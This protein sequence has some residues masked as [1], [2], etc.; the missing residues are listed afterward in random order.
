MRKLAVF[1]SGWLLLQ[2]FGCAGVKESMNHK[3][4]EVHSDKVIK[5]Y[6]F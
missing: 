1:I 4:V 2:V 6:K 3:G 5:V